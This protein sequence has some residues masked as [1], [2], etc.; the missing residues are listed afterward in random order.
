MSRRRPDDDEGSS[1]R[2]PGKVDAET[3]YALLLVVLLG[4]LAAASYAAY[5]VLNP[6]AAAV[7]S[8]NSKVSCSAVA[9]SGHTTLFGVP[10]WAI[11]IAGYVAMF[12]I[13][14][15]AYRTFDRQYLKILAAL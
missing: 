1:P 8:V 14:L 9:G 10:D 3:L 15:L 13:A 12:A 7:C 11:G 6:A 4:G 2:R 5:E